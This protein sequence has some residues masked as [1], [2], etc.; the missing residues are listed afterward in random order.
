MCALV[1]AKLRITVHLTHSRDDH[2]EPGEQ[3]IRHLME[4]RAAE[5]RATALWREELGCELRRYEGEEQ[6]LDRLLHGEL[7]RERLQ[8]VAHQEARGTRR[9]LAPPT[10]APTSSP[11][12]S[13]GTRRRSPTA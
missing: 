6:D 10:A 4:K 7:Q 2:F 3:R 13:G 12:R 1:A 11:F 5:L 9:G 8:V